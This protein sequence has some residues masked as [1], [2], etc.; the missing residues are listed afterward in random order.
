VRVPAP[1][2]Q[3]IATKAS[4]K[5]ISDTGWFPSDA[6]GAGGIY[7]YFQ[8]VNEQFSIYTLTGA[9]KYSNNFNTWF[10]QSGS[11][12]DPKVVW[13]DFGKRFIFLADSGSSLL[14]SVAQQTNGLGN[15]CNYSF[16]TLS[17][18]FADYPQ[19]G[20]DSNGIY[21]SAN[22]YGSPFT[23]EVFYANRGQMETCAT[24]N[25]AFYTG[26]TNADGSGTSFAIVPAVE[27]T[28][29]GNTEYM[30]NTNGPGGGCSVT[31]WWL[32]SDTS[33]FNFNVPTQ[34]Y[35][36]PPPAAQHGSAGTLETLDN[37]LY[38][39]SFQNGLLSFDT[40]GSHDW[41][42][43]NGPVGIVVWFQINASSASL[44]NQGAFGTPGYWLFF[45]AMQV[46]S[47]GHILFVYDSS[48][49]TIYPS[50]WAISGCLCDTTAVANGNSYYGTS[51]TSRW[52]DF[53][54][55]WRDPRSPKLIWVT[56]QYG[57]ATNSWGT[58]A[59]RLQPA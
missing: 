18:Y 27:H 30:V 10:G 39:A 59:A 14:V 45:P 47:I 24:A 57:A 54:S 20:V 4:F 51:G 11:L 19:L 48:G 44:A 1:A 17:G 55:A 12:F 28:Y 26:L 22:L 5:G 15:Y 35:S 52:G 49:P 31:L 8:T 58:W 21:F 3:D 23:N 38:E 16:S 2:N 37:R 42:D 33:L 34:C 36:P 25:F 6:N 29:P 53:Q 7:N 13:D 43:G 56:G 41:G 40:A 32:N 50:I 9:V 46:N